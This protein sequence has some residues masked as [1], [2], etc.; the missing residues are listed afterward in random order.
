[1]NGESYGFAFRRYLIVYLISHIYMVY[2]LLLDGN[3]LPGIAGPGVTS[4]SG[5]VI[6][7]L[8]LSAGQG[9]VATAGRGIHER[10]MAHFSNHR[11]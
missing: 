11:S 8:L 9:E 2:S 7:A 4:F 10:L 6:R 5:R 3:A 1:M